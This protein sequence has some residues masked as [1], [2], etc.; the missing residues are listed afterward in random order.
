MVATMRFVVQAGR[1]WLSRS[2]ASI[3]VAVESENLYVHLFTFKRLINPDR[4]DLALPEYLLRWKNTLFVPLVATVA[5]GS[6][7]VVHVASYSWNNPRQTITEDDGS[8]SLASNGGETHSRLDQFGY[9]IIQHARNHGGLVIFAFEIARLMGCLA[10]FSMSLATLLDFGH[11]DHKGLMIDWGRVF[12]VD[13]LPQIA[14]AGTFVSFVIMITNIP[15][16]MLTNRTAVYFLP[17]YNFSRSEQLEPICVVSQ[18]FCSV[19]RICC[20]RLS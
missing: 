7:L 1:G 8:A 14:M 10:L 16:N 15:Y 13:N 4:S 19:G 3:P 18:L 11:S 20:L 12:L 2:L 9:K 6:L 5:S 17:C